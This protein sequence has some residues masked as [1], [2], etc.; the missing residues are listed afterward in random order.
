MAENQTVARPYA[1]AVFKLAKER[2]QV[3]AWE[4]ML[5]ALGAACGNS[6]F[7]TALK[8]EPNDEQAAAAVIGLLNPKDGP[9]LLDELGENFVHVLAQNGRLEVLP[10]IYQGFVELRQRDEHRLKVQLI[11]ARQVQSQDLAQLRQRLE[12]KYKCHIELES[13]LDPGLIGGAVLKIGDEI[14]D[15]SVKNSLTQLGGALKS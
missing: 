7:M 2:G 4:K 10:E 13:A 11:S 8:L 9:E 6:Y 1:E 12:A 3:E 5:E 15:A 14:I